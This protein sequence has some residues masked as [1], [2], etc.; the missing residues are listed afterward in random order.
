M[1][2]HRGWGPAPVIL[3]LACALTPFPAAAHPAA[4]QRPPAAPR[5]AHPDAVPARPAP[6]VA[7]AAPPAA[8][9][10]AAAPPAAAPPAAALPDAAPPA[11]RAVTGDEGA[12]CDLRR[13][14]GLAVATCLNP[15]PV[16]TRLQLH[17][18]CARWWDPATDTAPVDDGPAQ[19][20]RLTGR[21][22]KEIRTAWLTRVSVS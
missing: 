12:R 21:C 7:P 3:A 1:R 2:R 16:S 10:P 17:V 15:D 6:A 8:E 13:E 22:W 4:V 19:W 14:D 11:V 18:S 5:P 20:V 9:A